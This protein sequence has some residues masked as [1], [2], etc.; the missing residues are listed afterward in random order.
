MTLDLP[1]SIIRTEVLRLKVNVFNYESEDQIITLLLEESSHYQVL[2]T[3]TS[4]AMHGPLEEN[5]EVTVLYNI[6]YIKIYYLWLSMI[7]KFNI[8][9]I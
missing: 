1:Y 5:I 8:K 4:D 2:D 7:L 9:F 6:C 3:F